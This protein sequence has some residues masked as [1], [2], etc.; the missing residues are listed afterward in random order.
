ML[1]AVK[2]KAYL[3][4]NFLSA[5]E[6]DHLMKL[7]KAELAPSTVVGAGGTSVPSTIELQR[8]CFFAKPRIKLW[9]I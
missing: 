2:P 9:K 4:R 8:E 3:F 5:E 6:C 7:A 1:S